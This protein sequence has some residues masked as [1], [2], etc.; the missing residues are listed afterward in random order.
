MKVLQINAVYGFGSTGMIVRD[1]REYCLENGIECHVAYAFA[2]GD[3]PGGYRIG[4]VLSRKWHALLSR[5]AGKQAYYSRIATWRL[6]RY[7]DSLRPDIVHLHNLHS[8][9]IHLNMLLKYLAK[10][11]IRTVI[12]L[13]DC[14]WYTGGCF[15]YTAAG[16]D[17]WLSGCGRCPKRLADTP[18]YLHDASQRILS[19]RKTYLSAIPR[20]T[21]VGVSDWIAGE[22]GKTFLSS[23]KVVT[24][25]NGID[26]TV[27]K[28]TQSDLRE[29]LG[30][31]GK[32]VM[33]GPASKW[34]SPVNQEVLSY[35]SEHM[36]KDDVLLLFGAAPQ[37]STTLPAQVLLYGYTH[38]RK[39][40][41]AL[42]SMADV[43][44]NPTREES[45]GLVNVEAQS[46]GTPVV[47]FAGTGVSETLCPGACVESGNAGSLFAA[48]I[49][50]AESTLARNAF[51]RRLSTE[52]YLRLYQQIQNQ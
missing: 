48:S 10:K 37:A 17:K 40:L 14:W 49:R 13:H 9:Y 12:T 27:F 2:Q 21:I 38:D 34:L 22:A 16:C 11:D 23:K 30:L 25:H 41:A 5:V 51:D 3:V 19:D 31:T 35:F 36:R 32:Y 26:L 43:F 24:I 50:T 42:Y 20:L 28:P 45:F 47:A 39:E 7:M 1:I 15:H 4:S 52:S 6:L 46:C 33:L 29:K 8:N 44:V 18:A